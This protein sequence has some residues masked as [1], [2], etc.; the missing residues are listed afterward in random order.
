WIAVCSNGQIIKIE[1]M[2]ISKLLKEKKVSKVGNS[3]SFHS[4]LSQ[5]VF[6]VINTGVQKEKEVKAIMENRKR[7]IWTKEYRGA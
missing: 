5:I 4:L 7:N 6:T 1:P 3:T 2:K